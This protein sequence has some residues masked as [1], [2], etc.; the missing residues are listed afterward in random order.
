MAHKAEHAVDME[1]GAIV[2]VTVQGADQGDTTTIEE[3]LAEA[4]EQF[5]RGRAGDRR[6]DRRSSNEVVADKGYHSRATVRDLERRGLPHLHQRA[7]SWPPQV[8]RSARRTRRG[9]RES[10]T[11]PRRRAATAAAEDAASCSNARSRTCTRP[12]GMRRTHLRGHDNILKRLLVHA[13]AFNLGLW[14]RTLFGVGT[15]RGL[16]GRVA[17]A[18]GAL[19]TRWSRASAHIAAARPTSDHDARGRIAGRPV[20]SRLRG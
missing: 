8:D 11:D 12:V 3:T 13:G 9:L 4:A 19:L 1:T 5:D 10:T 20:R 14:M 7:G 18:L 2:G 17:V 6:G 16:Q 15:P